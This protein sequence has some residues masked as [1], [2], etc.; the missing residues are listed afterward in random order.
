MKL[1]E[2]KNNSTDREW[3]VEIKTLDELK[4]EFKRRFECGFVMSFPRDG[5]THFPEIFEHEIR[6]DL[7]DSTIYLERPT[8]KVM[9]AFATATIDYLR[10]DL[11]E[12]RA[13]IRDLLNDVD[14]CKNALI[15]IGESRDKGQ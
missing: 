15:E 9:A 10:K 4:E 3:S 2:T 11:E 12:D 1:Y 5:E 14:D 13:T 6:W 7:G 8:L